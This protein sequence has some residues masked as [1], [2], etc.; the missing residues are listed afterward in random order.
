MNKLLLAALATSALAACGHPD[1][2]AERQAQ[3]T[4][5]MT[6]QAD[7]QTGMPAI[8]HFSERRLVRD[9]YE[10]RD[11]ATTTWAYLQSM[12]GHLLCLGRAVGYGVPYGAQFTAPRTYQWV[13]PVGNDGSTGASSAEMM[14]QPEPNGLYMP[15]SANATWIQIV[16]PATNRVDVV[17]V[18]PNLVVSPFRL[19]P[20]AVSADCP[21]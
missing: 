9:I 8:T 2:A 11:R 20:P 15:D 19:S 18:E 10:R 16:N 17:Y 3:A 5:A 1:P 14:D 21:A 7:R 6:D 13:R 12:D 4:R